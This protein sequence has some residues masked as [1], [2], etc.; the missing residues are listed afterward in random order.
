VC[1]WFFVIIGPVVCDRSDLNV[2]KGYLLYRHPALS[3]ESPTLSLPG[4]RYI[5]STRVGRLEAPPVFSEAL[6]CPEPP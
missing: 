3:L 2:S 1:S 4:R 5:V 6:T